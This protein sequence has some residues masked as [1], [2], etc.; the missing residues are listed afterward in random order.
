MSTIILIIG[1][2]TGFFLGEYHATRNVY[3][4]AM[5]SIGEFANKISDNN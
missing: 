4:K 5:K 2:A 3:V 1:I